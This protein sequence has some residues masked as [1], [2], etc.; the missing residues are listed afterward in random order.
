MKRHINP[1]DTSVSCVS[2]LV[3]IFQD[4]LLTCIARP[5]VDW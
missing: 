5:V 2:I 1:S 3:K 4:P